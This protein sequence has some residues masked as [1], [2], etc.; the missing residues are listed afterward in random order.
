MIL[1]ST[2]R[3][4][5]T[6]TR[7]DRIARSLSAA[8]ACAT[9]PLA[10]TVVA[11][12]A[13]AWQPEQ[14]A[15][16]PAAQPADA[17]PAD[18]ADTPTPMF[19]VAF[20]GKVGY[21]AEGETKYTPAKPGAMLREGYEIA[22]GENSLV[23]IQIGAGQRFT[24]DRASKVILTQAIAKPGVEQTVLDLPYGRINFDV[25]SARLANDVKIMAPDA[26]L[27]IRGTTG[28]ME[29]RAGFP[30]RAF[31]GN[32]NR[33]R[34]DVKYKRGTLATLTGNEVTDSTTPLPGFN[35]FQNGFIEI[36][37]GRAR[38]GDEFR[39]VFNFQTVFFLVFGNLTDN[40]AGIPPPVS[41]SFT[42]NLQQAFGAFDP[43]PVGTLVT[44]N[45]INTPRLVAS[46]GV[47]TADVNAF[48]IGEAVTQNP[49]SVSPEFL[50]LESV[51]SGSRL[52]SLPLDGQSNSFSTIATFPGSGVGQLRGL[53]QIDRQ[54]YSLR[55][56]DGATSV[57]RLNPAQGTV[58]AIA[59][60]GGA[61][62]ESIDGVTERG[63]LVMGGRL[64]GSMS[65][66]N[67]FGTRQTGVAGPDAL[68]I[69][70]DPRSHA[71]VNAVSDL[72]DEFS[73]VNTAATS[74]PVELD[75][76]QIYDFGL[77]ANVITQAKFAGIAFARQ[78]APTNGVGV[79]VPENILTMHMVAEIDS[80]NNPVFANNPGV[81]TSRYAI[82]FKT[83]APATFGAAFIGEDP[84]L[85]DLSTE[86][87][88]TSPAGPGLIPVSG[89]LDMTLNP[90][91]ATLGYTMRV[92]DSGVAEALLR[93][94]ILQV[95]INAGAGDADFATLAG[96]VTQYAGHAA[97]F[98]QA[99]YAFRTSLSPMSS[100]YLM[101][102]VASTLS[103]PTFFFVDERTGRLIERDLFGNQTNPLAFVYAAPNGLPVF[104]S[105]VWG[106]STGTERFFLATELF[107][108]PNMFPVTR[109][110]QLNL[111][112]AA[113]GAI[114]PPQQFA[115][116]Q[117]VFSSPMGTPVLNDAYLFFGLGT[118]GNDVFASGVRAGTLAPEGGFVQGLFR[119]PQGAT[120]TGNPP[121]MRFFFPT[122][123]VDSGLAGAPTR[124]SLFMGVGLLDPAT[125][126]SNPNGTNFIALNGQA[127]LLE[128]DPRNQ[129]VKNAFQ[130]ANGDF[131]PLTGGAV[132]NPT[133]VVGGTLSSLAQIGDVRGMTYVGNKLLLSATTTT[134]QP[135]LITY[136]P[137]ANNTTAARLE[138]VEFLAA[139]PVGVGFGE[140]A[141]EP[142]GITPP[143]V[144]TLAAPT[145]TITSNDINPVFRQMA[146]S[147]QA[148]QSGVVR[149]LVAQHIID[150]ATNPVNC[151]NSAAI[152][153]N[154]TLNNGSNLTSIIASHA[155]QMQGVG[156]SIQDFRN[157]LP[158]M[159]PC[160][161]LAP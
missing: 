3:S 136:N 8:S 10:L 140:L 151:R 96:F 153:M 70:Y 47:T 118:L 121:E 66:F 77:G 109:I 80:T 34:I 68:V 54:L 102:V 119:V 31:G 65:D 28:G 137:D 141:S 9:G 134:G 79:F 33:G 35:F 90:M 32:L 92:V 37:N 127:A 67:P 12:S 46:P 99:S 131:A 40:G 58:N 107:D 21:K 106:G 23:Q 132:T 145:V 88:P 22:T 93:S 110:S 62:F 155:N 5:R 98:G 148:A 138:K 113:G 150:R 86:R 152:Q 116:L 44:V 48:T 18:A 108:D 133:V 143:G 13:W 157:N 75:P 87:G 120:T 14:P 101:P 74:L 36:N 149:N 25:T 20:K 100:L 91:F 4:P 17:A 125:G 39:F 43:I 29:V 135:V 49:G 56:A 41:G 16:Q 38:V 160:L 156:Q 124:G 97:G 95:A 26:T 55:N 82:A 126:T 60:F 84:I 83:G 1:R 114:V 52:L 57:V 104:G 129:F 69:E 76:T 30:T 59:D 15:A 105:A 85:R 128:L 7:M 2:D 147:T 158:A 51:G 71:I 72:R 161:P 27:A 73:G 89:P 94:A 45:S 146:Y 78:G 11:G 50:R 144:V 61:R 64:P 24:I 19:I 111:N 53:G 142:T 139:A 42:I 123:S 103:G 122:D 159:H 112:Q 81:A 130:S 63:T 6:A 154:A 115:A 117:P